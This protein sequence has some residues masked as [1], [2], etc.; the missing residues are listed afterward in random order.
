MKRLRA[1]RTGLSRLTPLFTPVVALLFASCALTSPSLDPALLIETDG[2][3]EL[4]V[5]TEFGV[6]FLGRTATR[7]PVHV[8]AWFS[9]GASRELATI[10]SVGGGLYA[11]RTEIR[12]PAVPICFDVPAAGTEVV[13]RGRR[14]GKAWEAT[15]TVAT[16]PQVSGVLLRPSSEEPP[17]AGTG[18]YVGEGSRQRLLGLFSGV[19]SLRSGE[20]DSDWRTYW[21]VVGPDDLWR[22]VTHRREIDRRGTWPS[23][24][25]VL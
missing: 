12:L 10:E 22:L 21:M 25:D 8:T 4:G 5:S 17:Q 19:L 11:A 13:L 16:H 18:V 3:S 24:E 14:A 6:V 15:A 1:T 20:G 2:G 7:G 23:R 9:D